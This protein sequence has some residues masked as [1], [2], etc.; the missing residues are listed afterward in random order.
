M[1]KPVT[2]DHDAI[3]RAICAAA[4]K[5][6]LRD[7]SDAFLASLGSGPLR[8]RATLAHLAYASN[9]REHAFAPNGGEQSYMCSTCGVSDSDEIDRD[10]FLLSLEK[11]DGVS[12]WTI[13][14]LVD[15][16]S[17]ATLP[18]V[19]PA[20]G[21]IVCFNAMLD[22]IAKLPAAGRATDLA[23]KWKVPRTNAYSRAAMVESLGICGLLET[24]DHPGHLTRWVSFWEYE[25]VPNIGGDGRPPAAWWRGADGVDRGALD[26]VFPQ[27]GIDR[28]KFPKRKPRKRP[29]AKGTATMPKKGKN[30]ALALTAGD[31]VGIKYDDEWVAGVVVGV[32]RA[33]KT[34]LPVIEFYAGAFD[35]RPDASS[36]KKAKAKARVVGPY[37]DAPHWRR[38]PL[39][40]E[41]LELFG[42]VMPPRLELIAHGEP[43]PDPDGA[44]AT[45]YRVVAS[46]NLLYLLAALAAP[47]LPAK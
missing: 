29:I 20:A 30:P 38:E 39:A 1:A 33:G 26:L 10:D 45:H 5:V 2:M 40:L 21:D 11:G 28:A 19:T 12:A 27:R 13:N 46:R 15:L 4:R 41:G 35:N 36:L 25:E 47:S 37:R 22:V 6:T 18:R 44:P 34:A 43:P 9:L 3:I 14:A 17:F 16:E 31:L 8:G 42:P 7:A 32:H 23:K 24:D